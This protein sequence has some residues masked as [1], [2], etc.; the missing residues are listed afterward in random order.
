MFLLV[1]SYSGQSHETGDIFP[2]PLEPVVERD[3]PREL[4]RLD[5]VSSVTLVAFRPFVGVVVSKD[6]FADDFPEGEVVIEQHIPGARTVAGGR[7][8]ITPGS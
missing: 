3:H 5:I 7:W 1:T 2:L 4:D 6:G 8:R